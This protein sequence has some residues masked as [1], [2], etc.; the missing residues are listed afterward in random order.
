MDEHTIIIE[1]FTKALNY[2]IA[3]SG[4]S[5]KEIA[6]AIN[7]PPTTFSSWCNGKHLPDMDKLQILSHYLGAPIT[8]FFDFSLDS[9][10]DKEVLFLHNK[11]NTDKALVQFLK[12]F[13]Q[14]SEDDRHLVTLL[15][16]KILKQ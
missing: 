7:V 1:N 3:V 5:K 2:Y 6:V 10:P 15:T 13:F 12:L 11:L 4:K 16:Y 8:Q 9:I 14:L